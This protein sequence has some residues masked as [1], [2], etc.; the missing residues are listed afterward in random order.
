MVPE[1]RAVPATP[2]IEQVSGRKDVN[3]M[4]EEERE[5]EGCRL[6]NEALLRESGET[7][8]IGFDSMAMTAPSQ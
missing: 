6:A 8:T 7:A 5:E 2:D 4:T 3:L 1:Q